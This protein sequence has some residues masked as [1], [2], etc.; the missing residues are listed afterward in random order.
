M[1][2][3]NKNWEKVLKNQ[4]IVKGYI[5]L[6]INL[7]VIIRKVKGNKNRLGW[8]YLDVPNLLKQEHHDHEILVNTILET[9]N[10]EIR[11]EK[12]KLLK[13]ILEKINKD[14]KGRDI[15]IYELGDY[16]EKLKEELSH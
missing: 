14:C 6:P 10:Q 11:Q 13:R 8:E 4:K 7:P 15:T 16:L 1:K 9:K 3:E 5:E 2:K 12:E